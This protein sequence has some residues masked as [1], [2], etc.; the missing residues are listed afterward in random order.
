MAVI[1][2]KIGK[3]TPEQILAEMD[4]KKN[5][6][7]SENKKNDNYSVYDGKEKETLP[8]QSMS[9]AT[10][11]KTTLPTTM[12]GQDVKK[13]QQELNYEENVKPDY[14]YHSMNFNRTSGVEMHD[15]TASGDGQY[16]DRVMVWRTE[17][18][19][20]VP[21]PARW[22]PHSVIKR[23]IQHNK[24]GQYTGIVMIGQSG[25][26]KTTMT[27]KLIHQITCK[28]GESYIVKWFNGHEMLHMDEHIKNLQTGT[29]HIMIFDDASYTLEDAKKTDIAKLANALTTIRHTLK[30]RVIIIMNIH[31]SKATVKFFRNQHFTFLTSV[32]VEEMGNYQ[33]LFK[34]KMHVVRAF[35]KQY[36]KMMLKGYFEVPVSSFEKTT[37]RY[38]TNQ[39]FRMCLV[40]EIADLHFMLYN[41]G[42]CEKCDP[43]NQKAIWQGSKQP[44]TTET[45]LEKMRGMYGNNG[46]GKLPKSFATVLR[47][48][49]K[50]NADDP[51][52]LSASERQMWNHLTNISKAGFND[53]AALGAEV[54]GER[55]IKL[56]KNKQVKVKAN[57]SVLEI[58]RAVKKEQEDE[59]LENQKETSDYDSTY[60][61]PT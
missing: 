16:R 18:G 51:S 1:P 58:A 54:E 7:K 39:P 8:L 56:P 38:H 34:D 59:K 23:I 33:D 20:K 37:I 5:A 21:I 42:E 10:Y 12:V 61:K 6:K 2:P 43:K 4:S 53:W 41:K 45:I 13:T 11:E 30:S 55:K 47:F 14:E 24:L 60:I 27:R 25:S 9:E 26:G 57:A 19:K 44:K 32:S 40:A 29:P 15:G 17:E 49:R 28:M 35:G 48:F 36:N 31:Y 50:I 22:H 46:K 3:R 52:A